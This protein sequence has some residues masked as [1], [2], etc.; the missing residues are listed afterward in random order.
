MLLNISKFPR[1]LILNWGLVLLHNTNV[2]LHTLDMKF[3]GPHA[4]LNIQK[5]LLKEN[6]PPY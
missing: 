1:L 2:H 6:T 4:V 3:E 5:T